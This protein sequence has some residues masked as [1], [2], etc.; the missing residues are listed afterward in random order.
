MLKRIVFSAFLA[1]ATLAVSASSTAAQWQDDG[2]AV[3]T[4][5]SYQMYSKAC[6]DG[7]GGAIIAWVDYRGGGNTHIYAQRID[8]F[9]RP[10]WTANGI[11]VVT[12]D[13][14]Q[15]NPQIVSDGQGGA[16]VVWDDQRAAARPYAE[17]LG[18]DGNR[19]WDASGIAL[20]SSAYG[21]NATVIAAD[22]HGGLLATWY[23]FQTSVNK[24]YAQRVSAAG[25]LLWGS[26]ATAVCSSAGSQ[27]APWIDTDGS[28]GAFVAWHDNRTGN[29]DIY[30][31]RIKANG[32]VVWSTG[33]AVCTATSTQSNPRLVY[34][35]SG[36]AVVAWADNR[37]GYADVYASRIDTFGTA[38]VSD[39][40]ICN[41][42]NDQDNVMLAPD[43]S[44]GAYLT[45]LDYR[46]G[47][48]DLL[49]GQRMTKDG[50]LTWA[51]NG[52]QL[53]NVVCSKNDQRPINDGAGNLIVA[54]MDLRDGGGEIYCRK[55]EPTGTS[56]W[57]VEDTPV[58]TYA[59]SQG[60]VSIATDTKQGIIVTWTDGRVNPQDIYAQRIERSGYWGWPS[61]CIDRVADVP[62]DQGGDV[63]VSWDAS[64]L[65]VFGTEVVTHYSI[66]RS[67]DPATAAELQASGERGVDPAAVGKDFAGPAYRFE[68]IAG[69]L[70][71]WEWVGNQD[72]H[73][74]GDY[75]FEAPTYFDST[76]AD[77]GT[78][79]LL[80]SAHTGSPWVFWD[81]PVDSGRSVDN[82]APSDPLALAG[83]QQYDPAALKLT[84]RSGTEADL[85]EYA[86]YRGTK[87]SFV[88]GPGNRLSMSCD[89]FFV[90][91]SW[92]WSGGYYYKVSAIDIHGNESGFALL[93]PDDVTGA[94]DGP[95]PAVTRLAQNFPNPFNPTTS[96]AFDLARPAHARIGVYDV[97]GRL[98]ARL[99]D[100]ERPAGR[101]RVEWNG[102]GSDGSPAG[103]GVYFCRMDA[104]GYTA[105]RKMILLR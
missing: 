46:T 22:G 6:S 88:P 68:T 59:G 17:R 51:A 10:L 92:S 1:A 12:Y 94:G 42:S 75:T 31:N 48:M 62:H 97:S 50:S 99:L 44:G 71:G 21:N 95:L 85:A 104:P 73:Y 101:H 78:T 61:A 15:Y 26:G 91:G 28:Y 100:A 14:Y 55:L 63:T 45:W 86:I 24:A 98:V 79:Y 2:V 9:G 19:L 57:G 30:L 43:G 105:T 39:L 34:N 7:A 83:A 29:Y 23:E 87:E 41:A 81:S 80:V 25:A 20:S 77:P 47:Y 76:S 27:I 82:L 58:C 16:I 60:N 84:W 8:S 102:R 56:P 38:Y 66:W 40:L 103:S 5:G 67:L 52:S 33:I 11:P 49:Y 53:S 74:F 65:D 93:R 18:P 36:S 96:I 4:E 3:C 35:G 70:Y 90:D 69:T 72:A 54:W 64:R 32:T 89:T 37:A 13:S